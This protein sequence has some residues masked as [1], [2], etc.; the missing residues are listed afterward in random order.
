MASE[1]V[2]R[3]RLQAVADGQLDLWEFADWIDS[4]SWN[5]HRDSLPEAIHLASQILHRF[6]E[7]DIHGNESVLR[8]ALSSLLPSQVWVSVSA[9][10]QISVSL[11]ADLDVESEPE[12]IMAAVP[13]RYRFVPAFSAQL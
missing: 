13:A 11:G 3:A 7:Y 8:R 1:A 4:Y 12:I 5:M 10:E 9:S 6:A 2:I